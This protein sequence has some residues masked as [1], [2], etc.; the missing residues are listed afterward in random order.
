MQPH[1]VFLELLESGDEED[2][3]ERRDG[4]VFVGWGDVGDLLNAAIRKSHLRWC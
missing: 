4:R 3:T 2:E 1:E